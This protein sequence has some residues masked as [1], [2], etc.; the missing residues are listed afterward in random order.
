VAPALSGVAL[1]KKTIHV[2][3][4]DEKPR[5]TKL[6]LSLNLAAT[7]VVDLKRT[8]KLNGKT[9]KAKVSKALLAGASS[10]KLTGKVGRKKLPTGTYRVT[11][12]ATNS[13]GTATAKAGRLK[14][15]P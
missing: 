3:G 9:V 1:T 14:V 8:K 5:A 4:L 15:V 2:V 10:I 12:R 13:V 6:K 7:V 11:V